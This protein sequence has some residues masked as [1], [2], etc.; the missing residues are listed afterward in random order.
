MESTTEEEEQI[1]IENGAT[2]IEDDESDLD[3]M[4]LMLNNIAN[5]YAKNANRIERPVRKPI[6]NI[7]YIY[8]QNVLKE[9][10]DH[11][12]LV[13]RMY[14]SSFMKLCDLVRLKA[15]LKDTR[16]IC[17]EEMVAT[18]LLIV[19]QSSKYGYT[20][21]TFKRSKFAISENFHK[22]LRALN[23]IAPDLMARPEVTTPT[24]ISE[25][26]RFYPYFKVHINYGF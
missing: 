7:G 16:H 12:R 6:S 1:Y 11:F 8:I 9:D 5:A 23:T 24:K 14:P 22:V 19:G 15:C 13:Y 4:L 3:I 18:F 26:T 2:Q 25:S 10:P 20:K 17:V 21:D